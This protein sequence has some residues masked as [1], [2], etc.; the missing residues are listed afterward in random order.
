MPCDDCNKSKS[1]VIVHDNW[2]DGAQNT[3]RGGGVKPGMNNKILRK[4]GNLISGN[5]Y[6]PY[7]GSKEATCKSCKKKL[8]SGNKYCA[9]CANK[10][11]RCCM[12]GKK[13]FDTRGA[14]AV[15][16]DYKK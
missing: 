4:P 9:E 15:I 12:C 16:A 3:V 14:G 2:K 13:T 11:G 8:L 10:K 5:K 7:K 6:D 1:G